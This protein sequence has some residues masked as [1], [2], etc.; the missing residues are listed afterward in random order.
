VAFSSTSTLSTSIYQTPT[1]SWLV[2]SSTGGLDGI[3]T[4]SI[5]LTGLTGFTGFNN[6]RSVRSTHLYFPS[7]VWTTAA[8]GSI[9]VTPAADLV[10]SGTQYPY[11]IQI[12]LVTSG[13]IKQISFNPIFLSFSGSTSTALPGT[14][15][16]YLDT[17]ITCVAATAE[18]SSVF[19]NWAGGAQGTNTQATRVALYNTNTGALIVKGDAWRNSTTSS[20]AWPTLSSSTNP[21]PL[22]TGVAWYMNYNVGVSPGYDT[23]IAGDSIAFGTMFD[24]ETETN[25]SWRTA[26]PTEL[27]GNAHSWTNMQFS[28]YSNVAG[29]VFSG[30]SSDQDLYSEASNNQIRFSSVTS[31]AAFDANYSNTIIIK[32]S[33]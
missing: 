3:A 8:A 1:Y 13:A 31:Q 22:E 19:T 27:V 33:S 28:R 16:Q 7:S 20:P 6:L 4:G 10:N 11:Q 32:D 24:P 5:D 17:W 21:L 2:N 29:V 30:T 18:T 15:I 9:V 25:T 12:S 23:R 14:H 26:L